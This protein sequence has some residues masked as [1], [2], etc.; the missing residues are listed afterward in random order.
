MPKFAVVSPERH[1]QKRWLAP[2][3]YAFAAA[4]MVVPIVAAELAHTAF[5]MPCAFLE[6]EGHYTLVGILSAV[7]NRN[8]FVAPD[9]RWIGSYVP[10]ALRLHPF[11]MLPA[12]G[13]DN[14]LLCVDEESKLVVDGDAPG[15]PFFDQQ[16][17]P[18]P[19]F[20]AV[21]EAA[22]ALE[23]NRKLTEAA[24]AALA[25]ANVIRPWQITIKSTAGQ[26]P[27]DGLHR[28][29]ETALHALPNDVFLS[30]RGA[31]ALPMA[32][33]QMLSTR[34]LV[35]FELLEKLHGSSSPSPLPLRLDALPEMIDG[36]LENL[37]GAL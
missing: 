22:T 10:A 32:Y 3:S 4:E 34:Q 5:T 17:N 15:E 6:R 28:V 30:L 20:K 9:G 2:T 19:A 37:K 33:T 12:G 18:S 16:G 35:A 31:N 26:R 27:L 1:G 25:H 8:M 23:R 21:F 14:L 24:V 7:V 13:T 36:L 11:R 29:D